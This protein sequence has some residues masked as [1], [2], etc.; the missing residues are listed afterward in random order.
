MICGL[1][2]QR[3]LPSSSFK[4]RQLGDLAVLSRRRNSRRCPVV[5]LQGTISK[6]FYKIDQNQ[7]LKPQE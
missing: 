4:G 7:D 5:V 2:N 1:R 6:K 3:F